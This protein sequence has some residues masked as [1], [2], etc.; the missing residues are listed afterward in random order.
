MWCVPQ[1]LALCQDKYS[2]CLEAGQAAGI[3]ASLLFFAVPEMLLGLVP[4]HYRNTA[5]EKLCTETTSWECSLSLPDKATSVRVISGRLLC[6]FS[7]GI[8]TWAY[9]N[10]LNYSDYIQSPWIYH[11]HPSPGSATKAITSLGPNQWLLLIDTLYFK[12]HFSAVVEQD[13]SVWRK[14]VR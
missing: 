3:G 8:V 13:S 9:F 4:S 5:G 11:L 1:S 10:R 6:L 2:P 7:M 12:G 14:G